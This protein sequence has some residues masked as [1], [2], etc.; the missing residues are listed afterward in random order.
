MESSDHDRLVSLAAAVQDHMRAVDSLAFGSAHLHKANK[1]RIDRLERRNIVSF[2]VRRLR[3]FGKPDDLEALELEAAE[4]FLTAQQRMEGVR[5]T[6]EQLLEPPPASCRRQA[7]VF[8]R[9]LAANVAA[10]D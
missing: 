8:A 7:D 2:V 5:R 9:A 10:H 4:E 3:A 6:L 1:L